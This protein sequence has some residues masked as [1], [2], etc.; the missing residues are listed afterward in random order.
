MSRT[1]IQWVIFAALFPTVPVPWF[2]LAAGGLMPI[3]IL[4][5]WA[6][7]NGISI[8]AFSF[9]LSAGAGTWACWV[10]ARSLARRLS[11]RPIRSRILALF[12][13][14]ATTAAYSLLPVYGG[15]ENIAGAG[16]KF[17]NLMVTYRNAL[18]SRLG[19]G[20]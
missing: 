7:G 3:P 12:L 14:L 2:L 6:L 13:V 1:C 4:A 10:V 8:V 19:A 5:W 20:I 15:G 18:G 17:A 11:L 9:G 16:G